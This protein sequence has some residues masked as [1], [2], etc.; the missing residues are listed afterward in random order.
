MI[1][2]QDAFLGF[3]KKLELTKTESGDAQKRHKE[4]RNSVRESFGVDRDFLT[5]SYARH[6][7]TK[8]LKDIDVFFV[9]DDSESWR[10]DKPPIET[11]NAFERCL[12]NSFDTVEPNRRC[13]TVEF[14][15]VYQTNEDG[16]KVLSVDAVPAFSNNN[17]FEIPDRILGKWVKTD[18][19]VHA[20]Q[21]TNK[22]K[23]LDQ[24][25]KPLVKMLKKW[26]A[27]AGKPIK[28]SFLIEVMAQE[29]IDSPFATYADE[30]INFFSAAQDSISDDWADPAGLGP[31]V[32]DQMDIQMQQ[33]AREKLRH[34]ERMADRAM[35]A[36]DLGNTNEA[37]SLWREIFGPYFPIR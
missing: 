4:V 11:L 22:N 17:G 32:S 24:N 30:L 9:L 37:L 2:V 35:R 12:R 10:R 5:G 7:K 1:S 18:P 36:E 3:K 23:E 16:G 13:I 14:D 6:T 34:A 19:E 21:A 15:K 20:S 26:N 29:L 28:P 31:A 25:W 8:P 27:E 33:A